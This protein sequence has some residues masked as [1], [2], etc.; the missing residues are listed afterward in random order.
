MTNPAL[1]TPHAR[2]HLTLVDHH[3]ATKNPLVGVPALAIALAAVVGLL[4]MAAAWR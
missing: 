3:L 4:S 2:Y 1:S